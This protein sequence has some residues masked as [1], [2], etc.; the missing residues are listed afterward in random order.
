MKPPREPRLVI[1]DLDGTLVDS[2]PTIVNGVA[3]ALAGI[4]I[5]PRPEEIRAQV[6]KPLDQ[7]F[8]NV[9]PI[10]FPPLADQLVAAYK[11]YYHAHSLQESHVYP[12]IPELL[13]ALGPHRTAVATTKPTGAATWLL[14]GLGILPL[15]GHVQGTDGFP[16]KPEPHVLLHTLEHCGVPPEDAVFLGD[17]RYDILAGRRARVPTIGVTWGIGHRNELLAAGADW[18]ADSPA[19]CATL[20]GLTA[21]IPLPDDPPN[22]APGTDPPPGP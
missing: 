14:Q 11:H 7:I 10:P 22:P 17:T 20:L 16:P 8:Q 5:H 9:M 19:D 2:I 15:L 6:G 18:I 12:G 1:F 21:H 13:R 4:H 3:Y